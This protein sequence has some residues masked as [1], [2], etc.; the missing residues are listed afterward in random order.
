MKYLELKKKQEVEHNT[1]TKTCMFFAFN[2]QQMTD[3]IA[4]FPKG[5]KFYSIGAGAYIIQSKS[6][7]YME[8]INKF[9][10]ELKQAKKNFKL[11]VEA[12]R[13]ELANHEYCIT[14]DLTDT[15]E[16]LSIDVD[17]ID[18]MTAE[19]IKVAKRKYLKE[20]KKANA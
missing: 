1:F 7:E 2:N 16:S 10:A 13:Y 9:E 15:L 20:S 4:K 18:D 8:L 6:K 17:D 11:L 12:I 19:A 3:G 14:Y 5:T